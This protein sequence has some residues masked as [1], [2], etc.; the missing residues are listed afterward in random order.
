M[1]HQNATRTLTDWRPPDIDQEALR[2]EFLL[3][4]AAFDDAL[5]RGCGAGHLTGSGIVVSHDESEVALVFHPRVQKW[6]QPGGHCEPTDETLAAVAL[7]EATEETGV[8]GLVVDDWPLELDIHPFECPKGSAN[9]HLDVRYR[10]VAPKGS[11]VVRSDESVEVR[12]FDI[13]A[14]PEPIAPSARRAIE[15]L[16][17]RSG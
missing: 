5:W 9:R 10:C 1:L 6:V 15:R 7:R 12:W 16:S 4:L 8:M 17:R 2:R 3:H 11:L 13:D 14:L